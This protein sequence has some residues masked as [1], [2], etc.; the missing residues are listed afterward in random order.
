M[1]ASEQ[2]GPVLSREILVVGGVI[3]LGAIMS[4]LD[5][6]IVNVAVPTLGRRF[7]ATISSIQ[8]VMTA[9]LLAFATVIPL[10][11]WL[12]RRF[13]ATRVWVGAL[14]VFMAGSVLAGVSWSLGTLVLFRVVQGV[15]GGL[16]MPVGQ[17]ILAQAAGPKRMGR[18]MSIVGIPMLLAPVF[19][20]VI[21]GVLVDEASW[22]WIFFINLPVGALAFLLALRLLPAA[23]PQRGE[24]LDL[25]GLVLL[26]PGVALSV[27]GL[28]EIGRDGRISG[29]TTLV[30]L[31]AGC[32]LVGLFVP[33]ALKRG[34]TA[35]LDL[36]LFR[37]RGFATASLTTLL[38]GIALF[39]S[40]I[41]LPL[42]YQLVR[43]ESALATGLLL[44]PQGLGAA[45]AMP[46]AG[47]LTDRS[48]A[49]AVI[50]AGIVLALAGT[51]GLTQVGAST[52]YAFLAGALFVIG[53]GLGSTIMPAMAVA[54]GAVSRE[55]VAQA[56]SAINVV[57]RLAGSIGTALLAVVLQRAIAARLPGVHGGVGALAALPQGQRTHAA[58][59]LST[60]FAQSFWV[61]LGLVAAALLP[62]LLLPKLRERSPVTSRPA[63][64]S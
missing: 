2:H 34:P 42:Y 12:S 37:S 53:L 56:T 5:A 10:S 4:I 21:G 14:T 30:P 58:A 39:G 28:A 61:A 49:R 1:D 64:A 23:P 13:G 40:L 15:G 52:S 27:Y 47:W 44:M 59:A 6:T 19:G 29:L 7:H 31:V 54:F 48:G 60:A 16:I 38:L 20:P 55:A 18:V 50:P 46:L 43:G 25:R 51:L 26:P 11:G 24:R 9:Y 17:A 41:L 36:T 32:A 57:Q 35:L 63:A 33:H 62:A 8:W 3:V 45:V 22:R